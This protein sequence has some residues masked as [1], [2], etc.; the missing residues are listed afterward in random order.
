MSAVDVIPPPPLQDLH[1][2]QLMRY[3]LVKLIMECRSYEEVMTGCF[4]RV[5][6]EMRTNRGNVPVGT[7]TGD[8]YFIVK[9]KGVHRGPV[10]TGFSWDGVTT[11]LHIL[12]EIPSCF[13]STNPSNNYVQ[14]NSISN[15]AFR[16]AEYEEWVRLHR[17]AQCPFQSAAQLQLR[18]QTLNEHLEQIKLINARQNTRGETNVDPAVMEKLKQKAMSEVE[19][20]YALLPKADELHQISSDELGNLQRQCYEMMEALRMQIYNR[21]RCRNCLRATSTIICYPCKHQVMCQACAETTKECPAP[22]CG[23]FIQERIKPYKE[24]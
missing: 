20:E 6:L 15:S 11:D 1:Q 22:N 7:T 21:T 19:N 10:Y 23:T 18:R 24:G 17:E 5:L 14:L 4:A 2:L 3:T 12:I 9:I 13:R 16:Q 8:N